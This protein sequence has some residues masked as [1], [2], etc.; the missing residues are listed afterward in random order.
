MAL[1]DQW[2]EAALV[3]L[4]SKNLLRSTRPISL[5]PAAA[6]HLAADEVET[7]DGPRQW[8][9]SSV[10]VEMDERAF[11]EWLSELPDPGKYFE[12]FVFGIKICFCPILPE[13][14]LHSLPILP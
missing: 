14:R 1:W 7:F 4:A 11:R 13:F 3:K 6:L 10:E 2:V 9:R 8:D 5:T 12:P